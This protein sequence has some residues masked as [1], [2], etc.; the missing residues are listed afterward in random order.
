M[1]RV[2][3]RGWTTFFFA[4][5]FCGLLL[6]C[7]FFFSLQL[8]V[9]LP[10]HSAHSAHSALSPP[11]SAYSSR[12]LEQAAIPALAFPKSSCHYEMPTPTCRISSAVQ[13][14]SNS[15]DC[16]ESPGRRQYGLQAPEAQRRYVVFQPDLGGWNNIRMA[17]EVVILFALVT[18]RILVMPPDA[19]LYLLSK[20]KKWKDNFSNM[21]D[22]FNFDLLK[23]GNAVEVIPMTDFLALVRSNPRHYLEN[24]TAVVPPASSLVKQPLWDF[25]EQTCY[26]RQWSPG[27]TFLVFP[28]APPA[29]LDNTTTRYR[30][31][32]LNYKRV[33]VAYESFSNKSAIFFAGHDRNRMLTLFYGYLYMARDDDDRLVKRF[34]RDRMRYHDKIFCVGGDI[35]ESLSSGSGGR[36]VAYHIR[37]GDFQ[38]KHTQLSAQQ[39]IDATK[40][41][42]HGLV[43]SEHSVYISTDESNLSFF[44][45]FKAIFRHVLFLGNYSLA[46]N[47]AALDQN[48]LGM[49]EQVICAGAYVFIGTPLSTFTG[50]ISRMRGY[51]NRTSPGVYERTYYFMPKQ[52]HQLHKSPH[53]AIPM[54][55]R[56][57]VEAFLNIDDNDFSN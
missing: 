13:Y 46:H 34:V 53:L 22:Y 31:H 37:R 27:K 20:N 2:S 1:P 7:G 44:D 36:Y 57:Y 14:W 25:L 39:I 51:K 9:S 24:A 38:H 41:L 32:S 29:K 17:L 8:H 4:F 19:V 16:F 23:A 42:F 28:G 26:W 33:P 15:T 43:P 21:D 52:M 45:P 30:S 11:K 55:P 18:G 49:V 6:L 47:L 40:H 12:P 5:A 50:Y 54:W 3:L 35:V 56:E 10:P 48:H